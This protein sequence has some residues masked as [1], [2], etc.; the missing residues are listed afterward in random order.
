MIDWGM[1]GQVRLELTT[2]EST[3][4]TVR[5]D[6]NYTV[7]TRMVEPTGLEPVTRKAST[8]RSTN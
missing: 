8:C 2:A 5:G 6:A 3:G 4:F 7:L 1:V